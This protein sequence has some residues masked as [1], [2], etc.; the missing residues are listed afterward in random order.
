MLLSKC[1]GSLA[2][3]VWCFAKAGLRKTNVELITKDNKAM[4]LE[5]FI[6]KHNLNSPTDSRWE[7][8]NSDLRLLVGN[9]KE[10]KPTEQITEVINYLNKIVNK[11]FSPNTKETIKFVGARLKQYSIDDCKKVIDTKAKQWLGDTKMQQ[12]LCPTTLFSEANFEKY[13]NETPAKPE[14]KLGF[15]T[16]TGNYYYDMY[17]IE[18][19]SAGLNWMS[20]K[21]W[22]IKNV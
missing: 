21:E 9:K 12:Y 6:R 7:E 3:N 19:K 2:G 20:Y 1:Q 11:K 15:E 13:I 17:V 8:F 18:C 14:P 16:H 5:D 22:L 4:S 10:T